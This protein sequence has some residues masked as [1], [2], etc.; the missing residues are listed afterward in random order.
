MY[1]Y[2]L[3]IVF[4][5]LISVNITP[6][7]AGDVEVIQDSLKTVLPGMD[8]TRIEPSA[9]PGMYAVLI[10]AEVF[11]VSS[12][13]QYLLRGDLIDIPNK[14]NLSEQ[15]RSV[16]RRE[17]LKSVPE[18][19]YIEYA[20]R[21]PEHTIYVFTDITCGFCQRLQGDINDI[22][23]NGIAVKYL[24]FPREGVD[25][26]TS[27]RMESVWCAEDRQAALS[28]AMIGLNVE[29]A[30]CDNPVTEHYNLGQTMGVR[31]TPAIYTED[32]RYLPGY[33]PPD[34]LLKVITKK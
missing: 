17:I 18:E 22:N 4:A 24:A 21:D 33:M 29:Q 32:G 10:G 25:S 9:I 19:Q 2:S 6:V 1:P 28:N 7:R 3:A 12:D 5:L 34:E 31:G 13:G 8:I 27:R 14:A 26:E 20:P 15:Q 16:A 23:R 30:S 11:Y